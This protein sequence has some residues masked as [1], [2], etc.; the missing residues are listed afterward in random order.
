MNKLK[1]GCYVYFKDTSFV[2]DKFLP[3]VKKGTMMVHIGDVIS[4]TRFGTTEKP[5][6][7]VLSIGKDVVTFSCAGYNGTMKFSKN[8]VERH[9][10][11]IVEYNG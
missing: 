8:E 10:I 11:E 2:S 4:F 9:G 5:L 7:K 6:F 3:F 1:P